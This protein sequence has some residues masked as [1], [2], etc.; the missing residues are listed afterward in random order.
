[1]TMTTRKKDRSAGSRESKGL[2]VIFI[3][4]FIYYGHR[5]YGTRSPKRR[6]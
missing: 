3:Y 4:G 5:T 1:M 2:L 6:H